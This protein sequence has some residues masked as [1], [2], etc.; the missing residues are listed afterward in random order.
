MALTRIVLIALCLLAAG[1]NSAPDRPPVSASGELHGLSLRTDLG[2]SNGSLIVE[3]RVRNNRPEVVYLDA[4]QC[5]RVTEAALARTIFEPVGRI[6]SGS[7]QAVK[8]FILND[9]EGR[10]RPDRF[11]PRIPGRTS[12]DPPPCVRPKRP[13]ALRPAQ[14]IRERWELPLRDAYGLAAVGSAATVV[15]VDVVEAEAPDELHFLDILSTGAADEIRAGR[16]VRV[17]QPVSSVLHR[18]PTQRP[19]RPNNAELYDRMLASP[20]LRRWIEGQPAD[21]WK[22]VE[23]GPDP[24]RG[25]F[26]LRL[27]GSLYERAALATAKSDGT[28]V[29]V[30]VPTE[31]DRARVYSR[32]R[33]TL[34]AGIALIDEPDGYELTEDLL[35]GSLE[36]PS[37]RVVV[38]ES[39]LDEKPL[40][41]RVEPGSYRAYATLATYEEKFES[42]ALA[43]LVLSPA[44]TVRWKLSGQIGVDGGSATFASAEAA[45][46]MRKTIDR[47]EQEWYDLLDRIFDSAAAHDHY[48]TEFALGPG[49]NL[50]QFSSGNGDGRYPV[51]VGYDAAGHPT[52]V[53]VD[54][55]LLHL[56]WPGLS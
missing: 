33:G 48:A 8:R 47:D 40:D 45:D 13:F 9:Q 37:G 12:T 31:R 18:A 1:C 52:R 54:F 17:Q 42:V 50:V 43:T 38:G 30:E 51:F 23:L 36:L 55:F 22:H 32:R 34:P 5:G 15:R 4:D 27:V 41:L 19:R 3:A 21:S 28:A 53:V 20:E 35:P 14:E 26:R 56:S 39:L 11:A 29:S 6:W 44:P 10:Q 16:S 2:Y 7:L 24:D 49:V 25:R 46:L